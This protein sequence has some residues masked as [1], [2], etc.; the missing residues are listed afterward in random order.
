MFMTTPSV[1][2]H[3]PLLELMFIIS[4]PFFITT[5]FWCSDVHESSLS[6]WSLTYIW[7]DIHDN[8]LSSWSLSPY[9]AGVHEDPLSFWSLS[10]PRGDVHGKPLQFLITVLSSS[11]CS[12]RAPSVSFPSAGTQWIGAWGHSVTP[13]GISPT[14]ENRAN[15]T[16]RLHIITENRAKLKAGLPMNTAIEES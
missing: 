8:P 15:L 16:S 5:L 9:W 13:T 7:A 3:W 11:W 12:W 1:Y 10:S 2:D 6:S 14:A 4:P